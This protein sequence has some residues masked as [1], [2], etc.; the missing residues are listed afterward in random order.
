MLKNRAVVYEI[1]LRGYQVLFRPTDDNVLLHQ[2]PS[3]C[4]CAPVLGGWHTSCF[5][6]RVPGTLAAPVAAPVA[7]VE[8]GAVVML[9]VL[10]KTCQKSTNVSTPFTLPS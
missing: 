8:K 1:F 6:R 2:S 3:C 10:V 5:R 9:A 4:L 7:V